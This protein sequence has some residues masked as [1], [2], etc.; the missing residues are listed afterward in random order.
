MPMR[1]IERRIV[2]R[3]R[4][5]RREAL[6]CDAARYEA[7][8]REARRCDAL[9]FRIPALGLSRLGLLALAGL[10][11]V[12]ASCG[13]SAPSADGGGMG[14]EAIAATGGTGGTGDMGALCDPEPSLGTASPTCNTL[15]NGAPSVPFTAQPGSPPSFAGGTIE[16]GLYYVTA[17]E[18]YG[19]VSAVGRRLTL[20]ITGAG[21]QLYWNGDILDGTAQDIYQS[22]A[23]NT[24]A[25]AS[26]STL[27]LTPTCASVSPSPLPTSMSYTASATTLA[28]AVV[29]SSSNATVTTFT[30]Q[31]CP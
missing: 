13:K 5:V 22:F 31:G 27:T 25:T 12:A 8:R 21:T 28:L 29:A 7:L 9:R 14:G 24:T 26:G 6:R 1:A 2:L 16:D 4:G 30:R 18:G 10:M 23:A 17:V 11:G 20:A 15:A 19:T 3:H